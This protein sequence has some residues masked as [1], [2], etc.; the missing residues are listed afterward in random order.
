M[1]SPQTERLILC[2]ALLPYPLSVFPRL[3]NCCMYC[4][5]F[6]VR[7]PKIPTQAFVLAAWSLEQCISWP[8]EKL[9]FKI[10]FLDLFKY[11]SI[12]CA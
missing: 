8:F 2:H 6:S 12:L 3:F 9:T 10:F 7:V 1:G 5:Y 4:L 11:M